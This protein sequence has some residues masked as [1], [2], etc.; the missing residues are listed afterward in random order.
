V[1]INNPIPLRNVLRWTSSVVSQ[2]LLSPNL[3]IPALLCRSL[4]K[5][6]EEIVDYGDTFLDAQHVIDSFPHS[7][8]VFA[9]GNTADLPPPPYRLT[10]TPAIAAAASAVAEDS[11]E[12]AQDTT[13]SKKGSKRSK[14]SSS[15][16]SKAPSAVVDK[17]TITVYPYP[18]SSR[19]PYP[20]DAVLLNKVRFTPTQLEAI[21]S[22][23][24]PGL[25]MVVGPPGTGKTD[26][27]VQ[28]IV[29]LYRNHPTQKI[30]I[31][32]HSNAALNDLFEKIMER[33]V[34]PRHLLRLGSG[35]MELRDTLAVGGAGGGG[36]GQGEAFS[37]QGRVNWSLSRRLQLLAQVQK[38]SM[39]IGV[40]GDMGNTC[41]TAAYF[42]LEHIQSRIEKFNLA[43]ASAAHRPASVEAIFP[44]KQYFAD[45][46]GALFTGEWEADLESAKGCFTHI[47]KIFEELADYRAFELLRS[48]T[49][50]SDFLLTKQVRTVCVFA[51]L[52]RVH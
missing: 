17:E 48:Q 5:G 51:W 19:G 10:V 22:G 26:V 25:T 3:H 7:Q 13:P 40:P 35:E 46:P 20:E 11:S 14:S 36:K 30:L 27:A 45:A 31:V 32:T 16:K 44:F 43:V 18:R 4:L 50:R 49:L 47:S 23:T 1:W 24:N 33:D 52:A 38:L 21:R 8:V 29:N 28:I 34:A 41:E 15:A 37:K 39:S 9:A 6:A 12:P 42:Q 2:P